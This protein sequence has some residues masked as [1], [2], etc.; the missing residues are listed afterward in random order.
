MGVGHLHQGGRIEFGSARK[1]TSYLPAVYRPSFLAVLIPV[2]HI[3]NPV[4]NSEPP[5]PWL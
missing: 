2:L 3:R 5:A 1:V 4:P